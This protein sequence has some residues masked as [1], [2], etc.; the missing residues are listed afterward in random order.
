MINLF[1]DA[2][3]RWR[4]ER[5]ITGM[6]DRDMADRDMADLGLSGG[7]REQFNRMPA[8][9]QDRVTAMARVFGLSAGAVKRDHGNWLDLVETCGS[10]TDRA[11]CERLLQKGECANPRDAQ[12][13]PNHRSFKAHWRTA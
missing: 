5:A 1:R 2:I 7:Q 3:D 4:N 11:A 13:C 9:T 8:D 10:C 12:F 6:A